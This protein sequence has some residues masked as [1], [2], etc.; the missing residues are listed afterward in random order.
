[1][2]TTADYI[3]EAKKALNNPILQSAL[4]DLQ[5]R[6]GRGTALAYQNLPE[7]PDLRFKAHDIRVKAIENL[8]VLL[9]TLAE[10]VRKNGGHVYFAHDAQ[11]A[12]DYCLATARGHKIKLAVKGKSMVSEEIGLNTA[13]IDA[14]IEV[15]E[16]DLGEYIIQLAGEHPSHIIAPAIHKSRKDIGRLFADKIGIPYTD[17][18][19]SLTRAARKALRAKFLAAEMGFSGCNLACAET[20]HI[21]TVSNEGNIRMSTTMPKVHV[22]IMGME[23]IAATLEDHD[24]LLRLLCRGAAAQNMA[25]YVSYIGGPRYFGQVDGPDEFH[26]VILDNGRS[27]ILA[28]DEF[29]EMLCCIR[30]AACLNVCPV[31]G[32]IGGHS[33][34]HPYSGPVGAVVMPLLA[35]I[36]RFK[37]LC[38]GETLCGACQDACPVNIDLPRMLLA[39]R[40]KLADGDPKWNVSRASSTEKSIFKTWSWIIGNR[41]VYDFFL[42]MA[43]FGQKFFPQNNDM[44]RRL[45]PPMHGWTRRR[46]I[47]SM[48]K[49][50]F[51]DRW[52]SGELDG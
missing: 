36:N 44:I 23:R 51:M 14:G 42:R 46:D 40:A 4:A 30:C 50:S 34:G 32:K 12:V 25:T 26:L 19:P 39:L 1:M 3:A 5:A 20:G 9:E 16:T 22:A 17:D 52:R 33:Y 28:D 49:K 18:P 27:R 24:V 45:P 29:K 38:Q 8:D 11:S 10:N 47:R 35:G 37:D 31:Y 6:F 13:L 21:V 48:A 41:R 7:G 43:F 15:A 2:I